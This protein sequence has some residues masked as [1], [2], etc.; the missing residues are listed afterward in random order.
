MSTYA[1]NNSDAAFWI[2]L[3]KNTPADLALCEYSRM[4]QVE[5]SFRTT[6]NKLIKLTI[7]GTQYVLTENSEEGIMGTAWVG[8]GNSS[9]IW[10]T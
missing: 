1:A 5:T 8:D 4:S 9:F 7:D 3:L 6:C 2:L 10:G